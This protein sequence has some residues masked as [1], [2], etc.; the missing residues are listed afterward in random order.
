[1]QVRATNAEGDGLYSSSGSGRTN[2]PPN[3]CPVFTDGTA[4]TRG[5]DEN[6]G[7]NTNIGSAVSAT[8][9]D[10]DRLTYSSSGADAASFGLNTAT[11]QL[12][13]SA[14]LDHEAKSSYSFTMTASDGKCTDS[15]SVTVNV[16]DEDEPPRAPGAPTVTA[17]SGSTTRLDVSWTA[18]ANYG[19]PPITS[20]DLQY[21]RG[22]A[23]SFRNGPQ[24]VSGASATILRLRPDTLYQ[25]QVR[26]TNAEGDGPYSSSGSGRTNA[27]PPVPTPTP[28]PV[29]MPQP[30][31]TNLHTNGGGNGHTVKIRW[32]FA[33]SLT[34]TTYKAQFAPEDCEDGTCDPSAAKFTRNLIGV[35]TLFLPTGTVVEGTLTG[36][37]PDTLYQIKLFSVYKGAD[38]GLSEPVWAYTTRA[39]L[40]GGDVEVATSQFHGHVPKNAA[41]NHEFAYRIC[42]ETITAQITTHPTNPALSRSKALITQDMRRAMAKWPAE[43][44]WRQNSGNI[45]KVSERILPESQRCSRHPIPSARGHFEVKFVDEVRIKA[46]CSSPLSVFNDKPGPNACWRSPTWDN[47]R[48]SEIRTG[49]ILFNNAR[50][51]DWNNLETKPNS[52]RCTRLHRTLAHEVGHGL[53]M[54]KG[55]L[56]DF[57][58]HPTNGERMIMSK[59][60]NWRYCSPQ[61]YDVVAVKALYQSR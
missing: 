16:G 31:P 27:P 35:R 11:G 24:N 47:G 21:R 39:P 26:A 33:A 41:G 13:T 44:V 37:H 40:L 51:T 20:Y 25:V 61:P 22:T 14:N 52:S 34:G 12:R 18:P 7:S 49:S 29:P 15:I 60:G 58:Q 3:R 38:S 5:V 45:L 10:G 30:V 43:V 46:A 48:I 42:T 56:G 50:K 54:G 59:P 55:D 19:R 8:D 28:T 53:G 1:M 9:A 57:D 36:L 17:A 6:T 2:A 32:D 4:T 23:G